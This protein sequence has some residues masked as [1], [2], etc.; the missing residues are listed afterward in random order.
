MLKNDPQAAGLKIVVGDPQQCAGQDE[1]A[2]QTRRSI[3]ME[4]VLSSDRKKHCY[5]M[6]T[7]I[8]MHVWQHE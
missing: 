5:M 4:S 3:G 2:C 6:D 1:V 7:A 8:L